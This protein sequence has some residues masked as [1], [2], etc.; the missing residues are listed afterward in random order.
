MNSLVSSNRLQGHLCRCLHSSPLQYLASQIPVSSASLNSS[1]SLSSAQLQC[2]QRVLQAE[3]C[4]DFRAYSTFLFQKSQSYTAYWPVMHLQRTSYPW[5]LILI[6]FPV[7]YLSMLSFIHFIYFLIIF[8]LLT[9]I[10]LNKTI[11]STLS[12]M[13]LHLNHIYLFN[14]YLLC[15]Y[16]KGDIY[17]APT[18]MHTISVV[19][20]NME[21][22]TRM[23]GFKFSFL[24]LT[25][26]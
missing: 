3:S 26:M 16:Y 20:K 21:S 7:R 15:I 13:L 6:I 19:V 5:L 24:P 23:S 2:G 9:H 14:R 22:I 8:L 11:S 10:L 4:D 17:Y 18:I 12:H 25:A 1:L